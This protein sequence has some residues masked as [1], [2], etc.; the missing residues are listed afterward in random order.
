MSET[1]AAPKPEM[2]YI[3][4]E[5]ME[6]QFYKILVREGMKDDNATTCAKV[7]TQ[8]S[9]DGVYTHGVNRFPRFVQYIQEKH[10]RTDAEPG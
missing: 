3:S 7:F 1:N 8:N 4:P 2:K 6:R 10:V 9:V 5:E